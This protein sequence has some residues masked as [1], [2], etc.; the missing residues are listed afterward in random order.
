MR[1]SLVFITICGAMVA[2]TPTS[3]RA[4]LDTVSEENCQADSASFRASYAQCELD[5]GNPDLC[6]SRIKKLKEK[7]TASGFGG[8]KV[9]DKDSDKN[10]S[11]PH[12]FEYCWAENN[13]REGSDMPVY[14]SDEFPYDINKPHAQATVQAAWLAFVRDRPAFQ[15]SLRGGCGHA[16]SF[17]AAKSAQNSEIEVS[18]RS[19]SW[20]YRKETFWRF[21]P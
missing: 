4:D 8:A 17:V 3:A 10:P 12:G 19:Y 2:I 20:A 16:A 13:R 9:T 18:L 5:T 11:S 7:C 14:A 21:N 15:G 6:A 1:H